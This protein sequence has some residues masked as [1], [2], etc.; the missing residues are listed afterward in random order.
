MCVFP[1]IHKCICLWMLACL[2]VRAYV[3]GF[4]SAIPCSAAL[5]IHRQLD[6]VLIPSNYT[7][8]LLERD[9]DQTAHGLLSLLGTRPQLQ[10]AQTGETATTLHKPAQP[11]RYSRNSSSNICRIGSNCAPYSVN[12]L[13]VSISFLRISAI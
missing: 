12:I 3:C 8:R 2:Y 11:A 9:P 13:K 7:L 4:P 5:S 1:L 6:P 10:L